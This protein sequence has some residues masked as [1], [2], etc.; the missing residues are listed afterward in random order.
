MSTWSEF[1]NEIKDPDWPECDN[2]SQFAS[3]PA[4]IQ[5]ECIEVFGY[6]PGQFKKSSKLI[7]R[8]FP[9]KTA[10][11]CQLKWN[12][13]TIFLTT[14]ETASCHRTDH[15]KFD[16]NVFDFHNTPSKLQDRERMLAGLWPEKGCN[17][18]RD[19]EDAGGQSDRITNL[20]FS[21]IHAPPELDIDPNATNVTPRILEVYFDNTCNLKCLYCGPHFSSLWDAENKKHGTFARGNLTITDSFEK[22]INI[23]ANKQKLFE[24]LKNN[25][26]H[27]TVFNILG[28]EPFYQQE[29]EQCLDLFDQHPAP[30]LKLQIFTN[31]NVK[32]SKL[33]PIIQRIQQLIDQDKLRQF[34][35]TASLDCWGAPQEYVRYPLNLS[36]WKENFEYLLSQSW[37]NLIVSSTVTPLTVKTLPEL[38]EQ[39]NQW[40]QTRTVHH[41]QNSVNGPSYMFI[42]MF[43][44]IFVDDFNRALAL[45]TEDTPEQRSSKKYLQGIAQQSASQGPNVPEIT[46]LFNF[47][48]E[49]DRRRNTDWATVFPWLVPEF[50]QYGLTIIRN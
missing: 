20:D 14:E 16:T 37:I 24:W 28:G 49:M 10:T 50:A 45:K 1:Y 41:Y 18:C 34:E 23:E 27:L 26:Q 43:G 42:D 4:Y 29:L 40:N 2:E 35:I 9:I 32:L 46:K 11:A 33:Q 7:N 36:S 19:I 22:S 39:V 8:V 21:G 25:G 3:L 15:H 5:Q 30:E 44:D 13:S 48:N 17:Y 38:L 47:L 31:L 6:A 12:W